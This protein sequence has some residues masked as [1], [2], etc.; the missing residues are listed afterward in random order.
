MEETRKL[1]HDQATTSNA[2]NSRLLM[3]IKKNMHF[4][5]TFT[6]SGSNFRQKM[7]MNQGLM[8]N[9]QIVFIQNLAF[10]CLWQM[11]EEAFLPKMEELAREKI[12]AVSER[13]PRMDEYDLQQAKE[14]NQK[15]L[16]ALAEIYLQT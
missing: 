8:A 5:M 12:E 13:D 2:L 16:R 4:I 11:G 14:S 9:S 7:Q 10:D 3:R 6:P 15:V 1:I